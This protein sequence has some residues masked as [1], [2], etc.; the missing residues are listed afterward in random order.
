MDANLKLLPYFNAKL[1]N[2]YKNQENKQKNRNKGK[3]LNVVCDWLVL[4]GASR[5]SRRYIPSCVTLAICSNN[6]PSSLTKPSWPR[7]AANLYLC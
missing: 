6:V 2:T 1:I 3:F 4:F 7:A 5:L